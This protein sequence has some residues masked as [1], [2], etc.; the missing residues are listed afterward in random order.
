MIFA[1]G[2][3][4]RLKPITDS[5]PKALVPINGTPLLLHVIS[6]L[7]HEG[8]DNIIVNVHHFAGQIIDFLK[9]NDNFGINI[10]ISDESEMLLDTGGGIKKAAPFFDNNEPFL[11]HNVDILSDVNL[12]ELYQSHKKDSADATLLT[13]D[14]ATSRYLMFDQNER[15]RGW[16]NSNT[17]ETKSP[18]PDFCADN[19][20]RHAFAGIHVISPSILSEM[21]LFPDK[22]SIVDFY[23]SVADKK[24]IKAF[25]KPDLKLIDVGK[26]DALSK[27]EEFLSSL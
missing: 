14:R 25:N 1:A 17:G 22:F 3:G 12:G 10:A 13:S 27:A 11:V 19:Y 8:F 9:A 21:K 15:L 5:I 18:L 16:I 7:K 2:L 4:T 6:R 26:L 20:L 24:L 23:L